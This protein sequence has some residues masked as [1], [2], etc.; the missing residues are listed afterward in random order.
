MIHPADL[1]GA[2]CAPLP[3][4]ALG[5]G[6][7]AGLFLAGLGG[8]ALHCAPMCGPFVLGQMAACPG[9]G[10][11][12]ALAPYQAGRLV[13]YAALG[14]AAGAFGAAV[15]SGWLGGLAAG[16]LLAAAALFLAQALRAAAPRLSLLPGRAAPPAFARALARRAAGLDRSRPAGGFAFGVLLGFL[17]C[18]LL[19]AAL[20]VAAAG[21]DAASGALAMLAFGL[22][23]APALLGVGLLGAALARRLPPAMSA[24]APVL[25]LANAALLAALA[26]RTVA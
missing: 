11:G 23:T 15:P 6:P 18:G 17:P 25:L 3:G 10:A 22:G 16:L 2:L 12:A 14:G 26:W 7:L 4:A 8:G 20:A 13:T 5:V 24:A 9:C 21:G 1:L 19:Y